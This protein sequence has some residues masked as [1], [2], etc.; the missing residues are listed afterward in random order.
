MSKVH[1]LHSQGAAQVIELGGWMIDT[2]VELDSWM[3]G[4]IVLLCADTL[5]MVPSASPSLAWWVYVLY[6][7]HLNII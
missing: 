4:Y 1:L 2:V 3:D 7:C 5:M 6:S